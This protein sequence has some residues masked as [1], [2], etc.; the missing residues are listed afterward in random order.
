MKGIRFHLF[1]ASFCLSFIICSCN[2]VGV[3]YGVRISGKYIGMYSLTQKAGSD[4][5]FVLK[6]PI[7]FEFTAKTYKYEGSYVSNSVSYLPPGGIG[8]FSIDFLTVILTDTVGHNAFIDPTL[9]LQGKF[10]YTIRGD[11]LLMNQNDTIR[12]RIH[13]L[14]LIK[15]Y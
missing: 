6:G 14:D 8:T 4:S 3:D 5:A 10:T 15:Q 1:H 2:I 12:R 11:N 9:I 7:T 13:H